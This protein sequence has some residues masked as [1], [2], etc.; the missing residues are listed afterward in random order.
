MYKFKSYQRLVVNNLNKTKQKGKRTLIAISIIAVAVYIGFEPLFEF[1]PSGVAQ[2]VVG[3]S[4]GAIFVIILTMYLL[5]KQTEIEQESK[6]SERVFDEKVQLYQGMLNSVGEM[7][8]DG[9][10]S[11]EEINKL[12]FPL[13]RL[14]M[15]G[16]DETVEAF[17]D[18]NKEL[19]KIYSSKDD[20]D[21][22]LSDEEKQSVYQLLAK[23]ASKCRLDLEVG[24][25]ATDELIN[26]TVETITTTGKKNKDM[27]KYSFDGAELPKNH[28]IYQ[29]IKNFV[30][31]NPKLTLEEFNSK[32]PANSSGRKNLWLTY[33]EAMEHFKKTR[34]ARYFIS[35]S[36]KSGKRPDDEIIQGKDMVLKLIDAE[37]CISAGQNNTETLYLI[38]LF[39]KNNIRTE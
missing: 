3:A 11:K 18:V 19:N 25:E 35:S 22:V 17:K 20:D 2:S 32:V 16:R 8:M 23:F 26:S 1:V 9:K 34:Y 31:D 14:S 33:D 13:I 12:P 38:D 30:S 37:I 29:V 39:K 7:L 10:I 15:L 4:F 27:T 28:Y 5:N 36:Q 24:D 6:R 21:V